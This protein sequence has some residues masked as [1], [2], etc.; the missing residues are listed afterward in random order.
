MEVV[1]L[2]SSQGNYSLQFNMIKY[3]K[4]KYPNL[5]VIGVNL[6]TGA[7][8]KDLIDAS[9]DALRGSMRTSSNCI[10]YA[11][12]AFRPPQT[13]AVYKVSGYVHHFV[14]PV[15]AVGRN[16]NVFH[17]AK[18]LALGASTVMMSFLLADTTEDPG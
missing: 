12:F 9:V 1:G 5:Q 16:Q 10:T 15:L 7:Q 18:G 2:D 14:V 4:G 3:R 8:V 11:V 17:I 6:V 13:T